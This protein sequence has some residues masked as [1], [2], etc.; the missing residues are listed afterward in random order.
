MV[1]LQVFESTGVA[2]VGNK[3][4]NYHPFDLL[5]QCTKC[6]FASLIRGGGDPFSHVA[7]TVAMQ[8]LCAN[9]SEG[10]Q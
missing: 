10:E 7:P 3:S 5:A 2:M 9:D 6:G 4:F 8:C 1:K